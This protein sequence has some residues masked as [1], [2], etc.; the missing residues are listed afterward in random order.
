MAQY[1]LKDFKY[2]KPGEEI[3]LDKVTKAER[4]GDAMIEAL[5]ITAAA[6]FLF[7]LIRFIF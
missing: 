4:F 5:I 3:Q 6:L 2:Y 1:R 7:N